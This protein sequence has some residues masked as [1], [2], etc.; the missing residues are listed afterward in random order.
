V[1]VRTVKRIEGGVTAP[2]LPLAKRI[3][4]ALEVTLDSLFIHEQEP[5]EGSTAH[6][7]TDGDPTAASTRSR[8]AA[9]AGG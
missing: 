1:S 3:A 7:K 2:S 6:G 5:D 9:H 4:D 8:A